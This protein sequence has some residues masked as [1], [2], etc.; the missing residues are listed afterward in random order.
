MMRKFFGSLGFGSDAE[1]RRRTR[2]RGKVL[3]VTGLILAF[4]PAPGGAAEAVASPAAT[5][6][7][8][9]KGVVKKVEPE[10]SRVIVAH[11]AIPG[12]MEAMTMPFRVKGPGDLA[13]IYAGDSI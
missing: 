9:V 1:A 6:E 13:A 12:F 10:N 4:Y 8:T 7:F 11:D 2:H 3:A 5:R